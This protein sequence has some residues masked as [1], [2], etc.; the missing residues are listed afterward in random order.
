MQ[1][2]KFNFTNK[3][4]FIFSPEKWSGMRL[5]KHHYATELAE[6]GNKVFF[7]EPAVIKGDKISITEIC[8]DH[9]WVVSYPLLARGKDKIPSFIY[10][11]LVKKE[12]KRLQKK[13][14][15]KPDVVWCFGYARLN[16][17]QFF[18]HSLRILHPADFWRK[19]DFILSNKFHIAFSPIQEQVNM[20]NE[21]GCKAFFINHGLNKYFVDHA[22]KNIQSLSDTENKEGISGRKINVGYAG[23]LVSEPP[24]R[25]TMKMIIEQHPDVMFHFWGQYEKN[26]KIMNAYFYPEFITYLQ[27]KP[28]VKLYG[29]IDTETLSM[30]IQKMDLLWVCWKINNVN[31]MWNSGTNPHKI[32]E[33]LSTGKPVVT[34]LIKQYKDSGLCYMPSD[35]SNTTYPELF[36]KV[37][38]EIKESDNIE[39]RK[40]RIKYALDNSYKKQIERIASYINVVY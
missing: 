10:K 13:I 23:N 33:Y 14:K 28:N 15:M 38:Q 39:V 9:L 35:E 26:R 18:K 22:L 29:V 16:Q 34:H 25:N 21:L 4:I 27:S 17:A 1:K 5:S 40:A 32:L 11:W 2:E 8:K 7:L 31:S 36:N 37:I 3:V 30:E 20:I 24:D 12:M 6:L 19:K